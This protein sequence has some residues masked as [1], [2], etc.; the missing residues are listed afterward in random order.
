[1]IAVIEAGGTQYLV[2]AGSTITL[3]RLKADPSASSGQ[4]NLVTFDKVLLVSDKDTVKVGKPYLA[5]A[6]VT[7]TVLSHP[8]KKIRIWK[9]KSKTRYRKRLG[10]TNLYTKVKIDKISA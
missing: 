4:V 9:F 3:N 5:G 7:G 2:E 10:F 6:T 8:K 1:M